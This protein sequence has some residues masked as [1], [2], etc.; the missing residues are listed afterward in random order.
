MYRYLTKSYVE[1][2]GLPEVVCIPSLCS[3][4]VFVPVNAVKPTSYVQFVPGVVYRDRV[5][6][7]EADG[8]CYTRREEAL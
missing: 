7:Q 6:V 3:T 2:L 5:Y 1:W 4:A 8:L